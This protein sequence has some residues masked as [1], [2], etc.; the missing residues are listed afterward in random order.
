[1][2]I[3]RKTKVDL[4]GDYDTRVQSTSDAML[5]AIAADTKAAMDQLPSGQQFLFFGASTDQCDAQAVAYKSAG[6]TVEPY[7]NKLSAAEQEKAMAHFRAGE[8]TGLCTVT[9]VNRG[10]D[11]P[12]ISLVVIGFGTA[13]RSKY[14]QMCGG[15]QRVF[16]GKTAAW[17]LDYGGHGRRFGSANWD[18]SE[19]IEFDR[20]EKLRIPAAEL[21]AA[22]RTGR[23]DPKCETR[24]DGLMD[25][26][27][28]EFDLFDT[29]VR[30]SRTGASAVIRFVHGA[31]GL[32]F[33]IHK[34]WPVNGWTSTFMHCLGSPK[35]HPYTRYPSGSVDQ[36]VS[37][38]AACELPS[39]IILRRVHDTY[40]NEIKIACVG[41]RRG[42]KVWI[43]DDKPAVT[44]AWLRQ[45]AQDRMAYCQEPAE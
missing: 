32:G 21:A 30:P 31:G 12:A 25:F 42:G 16:P 23:A 19:A 5:S 24:P 40:N 11:L 28:G 13:S 26:V 29:I 36:L 2:K 18:Y 35:Y 38:I 27:E 15:A 20:I 4:S 8:L 14:E 10:F 37:D 7:H 1:L 6:L 22:I 39:H 17:C 3:D 41:F 34:V 45:R 43:F 33:T 9:K 44:E